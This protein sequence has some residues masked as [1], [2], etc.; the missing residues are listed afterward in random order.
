MWWWKNKGEEWIITKLKRSVS[1]CLFLI[2]TLR[3]QLRSNTQMRCPCHFIY[4]HELGH[5]QGSSASL[6]AQA[7]NVSNP[8]QCLM[9]TQPLDMSKAVTPWLYAEPFLGTRVGPICTWPPCMQPMTWLILL[10][11]FTLLV[12]THGGVGAIA[13]MGW[14]AYKLGFWYEKVWKTS[15]FFLSFWSHSLL[16]VSYFVPYFNLV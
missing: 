3:S 16:H 13:H 12:H 8:P 2:W 1:L 5:N 10:H 7:D 4:Q 15:V 14:R 11:I 6:C 9:H